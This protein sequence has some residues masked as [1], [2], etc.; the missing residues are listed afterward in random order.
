M[1]ELQPIG[2]SNVTPRNVWWEEF[3]A[4]VDDSCCSKVKR[5]MTRIDF[6]YFHIHTPTRSEKRNIACMCGQRNLFIV[7]DRV[8]R[9]RAAGVHSDSQTCRRRASC[10]ALLLVCAHKEP[11]MNRLK[12]MRLHH[13]P[14]KKKKQR[15]ALMHACKVVA[16]VL[17]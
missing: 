16:R 7:C 6:F 12:I 4:G 1:G 8:V 9:V 15:Y 17:K 10:S 11:Y 2:N 13:H 3:G 5:F 14:P